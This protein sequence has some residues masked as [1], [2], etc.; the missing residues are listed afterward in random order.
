MEK[1]LTK[2]GTS[3]LSR[4]VIF[5]SLKVSFMV[6]S[7]LAIINHGPEIFQ[8]SL[9]KTAFYQIALTYF[10]PYCVASYSS[11]KAIQKHTSRDNT[12]TYQQGKLKSHL[13]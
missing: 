5:A 3:V 1:T 2:T 6:G 13:F 7:I 11:V 4:D 10:V 8:L 12:K 9:S